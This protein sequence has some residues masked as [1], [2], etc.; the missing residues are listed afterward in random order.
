MMTVAG[1]IFHKAP[2]ACLPVFQD[3]EDF[4]TRERVL[5]CGVSAPFAQLLSL[6][7]DLQIPPRRAPARNPTSN[8][9]E[10]RRP[11]TDLASLAGSLLRSLQAWCLLK[12]ARCGKIRAS[13]KGGNF[14]SIFER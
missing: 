12:A 11:S 9:Q 13:L 14:L 4:G 3:F 1:T 7:P 5:V 6:V 10:A 2:S 8:R